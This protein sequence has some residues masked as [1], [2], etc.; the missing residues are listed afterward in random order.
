M[1]H[2]VLIKVH[3]TLL[4]KHSVNSKLKC[5]RLVS[6]VT[7][8]KTRRGLPI[9]HHEGYVSHLPPD[10]RFKMRKFERLFYYLLKDNV[11][12]RK[13]VWKPE[14]VS[15]KV[16]IETVHTQEY[17]DDFF[18]GQIGVKEQKKTGFEWSRGLVSRCRYETGGTL[19][20]VE[21]ALQYGLACSTG[22]GTHHAFPSHGSGFCLINDMA[23]AARY[24]I[25]RNRVSKV[26]IVDLDVHQGDGT[27]FIFADDPNVFTFSVHCGKNFPLHK[28]K[29]DLDVSLE[30]GVG[31][32]EYME[33]IGKWLPLILETFRPDLVIYDAGVDPHQKDALGN[34]NLTDAGLF[35]RD[36]W[37]MDRVLSHGVPCACVIGGGYS[38]D[39]DELSLRHTILHRAATKV[40]TDRGM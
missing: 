36:Y 26:L 1:V 23:V 14:R 28:Q 9:V 7:K 34:L 27:A 11:I 31:D 13:Q 20:A 40:W 33:E 30:N 18:S 6:Q 10:H 24:F 37:V 2:T 35:H 12:D 29:S 32:D 16:L 15:R 39:L 38:K 5:V 4:S 3:R 25:L 22:G 8:D 19:L 17:I 21:A